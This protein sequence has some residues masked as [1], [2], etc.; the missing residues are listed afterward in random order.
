MAQTNVQMTEDDWNY[1][2][3]H[4]LKFSELMRSAIKQHRDGNVPNDV[5]LSRRIEAFQKIAHDYREF[6]EKKGLT[7]EFM[8]EVHGIDG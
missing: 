4:S 1:C 5:T 2:K 6:V 8:K 3:N 7:N